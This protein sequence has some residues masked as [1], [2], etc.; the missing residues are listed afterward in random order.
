M[1]QT[2]DLILLLTEIEEENPEASAYL[3]N[4]ITAKTPRTLLD[5]MK[6]I[7][8]NRPLDICEFYDRIRKNHNEKKSPLYKNIVKDIDAD[9]DEII[10]T[11]HAYI[12]QVNLYSKHVEDKPMFFKHARAEEVTRALH[13]Y[14]VDFD[15]TTALKLIKLLKAD[16]IAFEQV[17]GRR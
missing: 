14:Y 8:D 3:R 17:N 15:I 6:F 16:L 10:T 1:L 7:N 2:N 11:L 5:A 4:I 13:N 12:L 9:I